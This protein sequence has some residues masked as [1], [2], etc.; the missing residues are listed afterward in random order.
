MRHCIQPLTIRKAVPYS[1]SIIYH[2]P[3][4]IWDHSRVKN[5]PRSPRQPPIAPPTNNTTIDTT[6][7]PLPSKYERHT[8]YASANM[9]RGTIIGRILFCPVCNICNHPANHTHYI[10]RAL[11][12]SP[13]LLLSLTHWTYIPDTQTDVIPTATILRN[14]RRHPA[15]KIDPSWKA[16]ASNTGRFIGIKLGLKVKLNKKGTLRKIK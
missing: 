10:E 13:F 15:K 3:G 9:R 12:L 5:H 7:Q 16:Y 6:Q 14:L 2:Y 4:T 1:A 11:K 8:L